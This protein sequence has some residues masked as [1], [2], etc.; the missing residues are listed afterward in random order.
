MAIRENKTITVGIVRALGVASNE[1]PPED[2][3]N[4]STAHWSAFAKYQ[5]DIGPQRGSQMR[6]QYIPG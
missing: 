1:I 6:A 5:F 4:R 3:S 2:M